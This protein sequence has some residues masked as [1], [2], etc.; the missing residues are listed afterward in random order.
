MNKTKARMMAEEMEEKQVAPL[1]RIL[2]RN[3]QMQV[4]EEGGLGP[5]RRAVQKATE[6]ATP[7]I[8]AIERMTSRERRSDAE[9]DELAREIARDKS[10]GMKSGG[11]VSSAS[12]RADGCAQRGKTRGRMV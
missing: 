11:K 12:K 8:E 4:D 1:S 7:G 2:R 5:I 6:F 10:R 9:L 3:K